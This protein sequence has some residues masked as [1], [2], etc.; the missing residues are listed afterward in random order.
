METES[1]L[2]VLNGLPV[3]E[4]VT[5]EGSYFR[6]LEPWQLADYKAGILKEGDRE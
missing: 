3:W 1:Y 4:T 5:S 2:R 6:G